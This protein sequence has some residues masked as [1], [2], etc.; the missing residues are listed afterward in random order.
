M[1]SE[2]S[3]ED[4]LPPHTT[5]ID[6]QFVDDSIPSLPNKPLNLQPETISPPSPLNN[7]RSKEQSRPRRARR[8]QFII[9]LPSGGGNINNS[10]NT[11]SEAGGGVVIKLLTPQQFY[12]KQ[13]NSP[14]RLLE[15]KLE[16]K[17]IDNFNRQIDGN[18][19]YAGIPHCHRPY[20][21][22][23]SDPAKEIRMFEIL[24]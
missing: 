24:I 2:D 8:S 23:S 17:F 14:H 15:K 5:L 1:T 18:P 12:E 7:N 3:I 10:N 16:K 13:E 19:A 9:S 11:N 20:V 4:I 21:K 22:D 6:E